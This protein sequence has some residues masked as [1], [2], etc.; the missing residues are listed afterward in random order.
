MFPVLLTL[1]F[2]GVP[3]AFALISTAFVFGLMRFG[4][5]AVLVFMHKVDDITGASI[6]YLV[7]TINYRLAVY[8]ANGGSASSQGTHTRR[9]WSSSSMTRYWRS[10]S[11][12]VR[13]STATTRPAPCWG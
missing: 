7:D 3:I 13:F 2:L 11:P 12:I 10:T 8:Q 6:L 4:E 1:I 9:S 5:N